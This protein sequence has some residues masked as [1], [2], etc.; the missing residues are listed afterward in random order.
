MKNGHLGDK[1]KVALNRKRVTS[2]IFIG[3]E[4]KGEYDAR[5]FGWWGSAKREMSHPL[6]PLFSL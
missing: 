5:T 1:W 4:E 2:Y 3:E 6:A